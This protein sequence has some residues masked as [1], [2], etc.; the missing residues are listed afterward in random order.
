VFS[1]QGRIKSAVEEFQGWW[2]YKV[3]PN[4]N[5]YSERT[6]NHLPCIFYDSDQNF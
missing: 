3:E 4:D 6:F 1:G 2:A 5:D